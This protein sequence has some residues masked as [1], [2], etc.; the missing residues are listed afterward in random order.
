ME[1]G[2]QQFKLQAR[3]HDGRSLREHLESVERQ[4]GERHELLEDAEPPEDAEYLWQWF[5]RLSS[6]RQSGMGPGPITWPQIESFFRCQGII[7]EDW[8]LKALEL[9]DNA[10][11]EAM[12][13]QAKGGGK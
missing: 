7:P 2:E 12:A 9:V 6:R 13:E 3:Q 4:T 5:C 8:E 1:F 10:W 11:L